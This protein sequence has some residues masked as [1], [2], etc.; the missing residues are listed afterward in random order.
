MLSVSQAKPTNITDLGTFCR[1]SE[2]TYLNNR[3]MR[4]DRADEHFQELVKN[5][6]LK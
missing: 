5:N 2:Q 6:K 4:P 1:E 3:L